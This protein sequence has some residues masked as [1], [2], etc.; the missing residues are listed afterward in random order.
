MRRTVLL[1]V[2]GLGISAGIV[3]AQLVAPLGRSGPCPPSYYVPPCQPCSPGHQYYPPG[4]VPGITPGTVTPGM[5]PVADP[6][7]PNP[8]A[9]PF[10]PQVSD[11]FAQPTEA[12]GQGARTFN[13]N[14]A[15]DFGGVFYTRFITTT[16][17]TQ[18]VIGFTDQVV[19]TNQTVTIDPQGNKVVTNT[20]IIN[21]VP[22]IVEDQVQQTQRYKSVLAGRYQG[23]FLTDNDSPRPTDRVY[24]GY[25]FYSDVGPSFNP[26]LE[27]TDIQRQV[28]GFE[29][30]FLN[31]DASLGMR[32]PF[33]QQYG[34]DVGANNVGDLTLLGKYAWVNNRRTGDVISTGFILT[35]PTGGGSAILLDG[36][37]APH[38][39]LFQ[40]WAGFIKMFDRGYVMGI[41][42]LV[43]PSDSRD[44]MLWGNSVSAG[45]VLYRNTGDRFIS[46]I[47]P[48]AEIHVRTP[49]NHRSAEDLVFLQDQLNITGALHIRA[50]RGTL[51][52]AITVPVLGPRPFAVEAMCYANFVF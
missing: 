25:T 37:E 2:L 43:V 41:S 10:Q 29:K 28:F 13:E 39:W 32:L 30:A 27:Q 46:G 4:T 7:V 18:R 20:P 12:G 51:S 17:T 45:Y 52:P 1:A 5:P 33:T 19:G 22:V 23:I 8:N 6:N 48:A 31:G 49:L 38:S 40:P 11:P 35:T 14:F 47:I 44:P 24:F 16:T 21:R 9:Q 26:G 50:N 36:T 3:Q 34:P 15:G 42:N